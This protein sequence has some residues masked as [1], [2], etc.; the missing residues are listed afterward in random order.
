MGKNKWA[1]KEG[2]LINKNLL[3]PFYQI[4]IILST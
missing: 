3:K 1:K 4:Y 2:E